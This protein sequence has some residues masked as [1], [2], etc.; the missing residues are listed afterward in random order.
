M[1]VIG[2]YGP[3]SDEVSHY[4]VECHRFLPV[5]FEPGVRRT[6]NEIRKWVSKDYDVVV[7]GMYTQ[8]ESKAIR[9]VFG[10]IIFECGRITNSDSS[11][12]SQIV[13]DY[14]IRNSCYKRDIHYHVNHALEDLW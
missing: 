3:M 1:V 12:D 11:D 14:V 10:G 13:P 4:M 8:R 7:S 6:M 5:T 9:C 2:L